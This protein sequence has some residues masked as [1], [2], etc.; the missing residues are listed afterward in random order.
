MLTMDEVKKVMFVIKC[1]YPNSPFN[2]AGAKELEF[3]AQTW[4]SCFEEYTY[5]QISAGLKAFMTSDT[6]GFQPTPAQIIKYA[7]AKAP[8]NELTSNEAWALVTKALRNS[9]YNYE[10]EFEKLPEAVQKAIGNA[11]SLRELALMDNNTVQ[12]VEGS[13]FKR[14]YEAYVKREKEYQTI[15]Q[16]V[17]T[18]L[19][20]ANPTPQI[21]GKT[22]VLLETRED[23]R[24]KALER[25]E[26]E[27]KERAESFKNGGQIWHRAIV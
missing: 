10:A 21:A 2:R 25:L 1:T 24:H 17:R 9:G 15:P 13:H 3:T 6:S 11:A 27:R 5:G 22:V 4:A 20:A 19:E 7:R 8:K 23:E 18:L 26:A 12:S 16:S 14:N